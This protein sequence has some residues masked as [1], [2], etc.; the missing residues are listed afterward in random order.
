[1]GLWAFGVFGIYFFT[2]LYLQNVLGFSPTE[3]GV[4]FVPMALVLAVTATFSRRD[5]IAASPGRADGGDRARSDGRGDVGISSTGAAGSTGPD[6]SAVVPGLTAW[7]VEC[8][9]R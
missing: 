8:W 2:A 5:W 9:S 1:M 3:A 7:A 4:A 6:L